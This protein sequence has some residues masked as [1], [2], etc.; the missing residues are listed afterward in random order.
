MVGGG[1]PVAMTDSIVKD[2]DNSEFTDTPGSEWY[3][4]LVRISGGLRV[5]RPGSSQ[6]ISPLTLK[7]GDLQPYYLFKVEDVD[8]NAVDL[9]GSTIYCTMKNK[10]TGALKIENRK[11]GIQLLP[12]SA[13]KGQAY[14][15]WQSEDTD[16]IGLYKI[17]F[18]IESDESGKFTVP[19]DNSAVVKILK[20]L[21][22]ET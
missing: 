2:T 22:A 4:Q 11:D 8:G 5:F 18:K 17:E 12:S 20:R 9:S 13:Y 16:T 15:A 19:V 14:L 10:K 3:R 1:R 6:I 21:E 7:K